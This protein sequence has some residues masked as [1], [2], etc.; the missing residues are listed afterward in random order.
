M[1]RRTFL[2]SGAAA[3]LAHPVVADTASVIRV[4]KTPT[5]GCCTAWV[6]HV[7][8]AGFAVE[9][10]DV[11]QDALYAFK[12]RL[13][14]APEL[15]GCH[16]AVAGDY[17]IEGHVPALDIKRLLAEQP[18]ARGLTVPGMPM[19]SPGMGGP[20]AGDTFDTLLVGTDGATSVYASHS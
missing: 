18:G 16:T 5:C 12:G 6:D 14:I 9:A 11:D 3:V 1:N 10:Q 17:F 13:Q 8:Q 7:R 2:I 4:L 19:S 15:A 20:G